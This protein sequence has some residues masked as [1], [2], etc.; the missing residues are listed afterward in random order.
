MVFMALVSGSV[1]AWAADLT[2]EERAYINLNQPF[3]YCIDPDWPPYEVINASGRHEGISADLLQ[4]VAQHAGIELKLRATRDWDESIAL[5]KS[6]ECQVL[7]FLNRTP[8]RDQWLSFTRPVFIDRNVIV[9]REE[10]PFIDDLGSLAGKTLV[11]PKGT[12]IEERVRQDFP[13]LSILTTETEAEAFAM[14]SQRKADMTMRS[15]IVAVYTIKKE[16]WFNLKISGQVPGYENNLR[17]GVFKKHEMLRNILDQGVAEIGPSQRA[18]IANRHVSIKVQSGIDYELIAKIVA[19]F[20]LILLTSLFWAVKLRAVNKQLWRLARTDP[21]TNIANRASI[22][23]RMDKEIERSRRYSRPFSVIL[24]DLD[25]FKRINDEQGHLMGDQVLKAFAVLAVRTARTQD[26]VGRWGGEE[27]IILC[28]ET[29]IEQAEILAERLCQV[30][31]EHRFES[32]RP[33]TVSAGVATLDAD[34]TAD[35][36]TNRADQA[37]YLAKQGGRDQVRVS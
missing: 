24:L 1:G 22:N 6:G 32:R 23:E 26:M 17:I 35:S 19:A 2:E 36:L 15:L 30:V 28:T 37:L 9:T 25:H 13:N 18:E 12:S 16:G 31:R 4:L 8:A 34:D 10:H 14:V 27:F 29:N 33:H 3:T 7:S 21:L 5:S 20:S 11:L